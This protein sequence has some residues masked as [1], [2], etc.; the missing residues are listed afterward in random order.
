MCSN[1]SYSDVFAVLT[2]TLTPPSTLQH[3]ECDI[4]KT[5]YKSK[6]GLTRHK[7]TV[8]KF[9]ARREDLNILPSEAITELS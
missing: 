1:N 3:Y 9:N 7:N 6:A 2:P 4:C 8:Q 5:S